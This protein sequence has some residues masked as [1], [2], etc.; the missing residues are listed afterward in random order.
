M[1]LTRVAVIFRMGMNVVRIESP[2]I[3]SIVSQIK[4]EQP[5]VLAGS[6]ISHWAPTCLPP[7]R[8]VAKSMYNLLIPLLCLDDEKELIE[9]LQNDLWKKIPFENVMERCPIHQKLTPIIKERFLINRFNTVHK[10]ITDASVKGIFSGII[11]TNYDLCF[12]ELLR[13]TGI[14]KITKKKDISRLYFKIHGSADDTAGETLVYALNHEKY[15]EPWKRG[16]LSLMLSGQSLFII[17]YSGLDFELCPEMLKIPLKTVFWNIFEEKDMS[18][19][20]YRFS[21]EKSGSF[22]VG[23]MVELL[24]S[25]VDNADSIS[26]DK[27]AKCSTAWLNSFKD[28]INNTFTEH[29]RRVWGISILNSMGCSRGALKATETILREQSVQ[30]IDLRRQRAE[31]LFHVGKYLQSAREYCQIARESKC[32]LPLRASLLL[33]SCDAYRCQGDFPKSISCLRTAKK[34][35]RLI[36]EAGKRDELKGKAALKEVLLWRHVYQIVSSLKIFFFAAKII[37]IKVTKL[38]M[39]AAKSSAQTGNWFEFQQVGLWAER[40]GIDSSLLASRLQYEPPPAKIRYEHLGFHIAQSM[41]LRDELNKNKDALSDKDRELLEK[42]VNNCEICG[43][44]PELWK[45]SL[46]CLKK[47]LE[48]RIYIEKYRKAFSACE[49]SPIMRLFLRIHEMAR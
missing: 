46:I 33:D 38:L 16:L 1:G 24:S 19:N 21:K 43:N 8:D 47:G 27:N 36:D 35:L 25:L 10:I 45:L 11:T 18:P 44:C 7:G 39:L 6:G 20:A 41:S 48:R 13:S 34:E 15:L 3:K 14:V 4:A 17:G 29:E 42:C 49:Y 23:D 28:T 37:K 22:L 31:A 2:E 40:I 30:T 26:V 5:V 12:D 9:L 32:D